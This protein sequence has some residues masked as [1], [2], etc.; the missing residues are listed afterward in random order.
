MTIWP[1]GS[2]AQTPEMIL[3]SVLLPE[4]FSPTRQWISPSRRSK[5]TP[6]SAWTPPKRLLI[7]RSARKSPIGPQRDATGAGAGGWIGVEAGCDMK[8]GRRRPRPGQDGEAP[9]RPATRADRGLEALLDQI[10]DRVL[11]DVQ[12]LVDLDVVLVHVDRG[13]AQAGDL[14]AVLDLLLVED[15]LCDRDDGVAG[16]DRVPQEAFRDR[17]VLEQRLALA[18]QAGADDVDL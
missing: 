15:E 12:D 5:S 8:A 13:D 3:I 11:G 6:S 14:H 2:G 7:A 1:P 9:S 17:A 4:P 10:V 18:G 16:V